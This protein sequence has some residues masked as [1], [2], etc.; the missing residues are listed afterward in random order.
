[1]T[2]LS[3]QRSEAHVFYAKIENKKNV[4]KSENW[5]MAVN[6]NQSQNK[7]NQN[8]RRFN[9]KRGQ[10]RNNNSSVPGNNSQNGNK[11]KSREYKFHMH[12]MLQWKML[13][14]FNNIKESI[15]LKV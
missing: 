6:Q 15:I 7:N 5:K 10:N 3:S 13:E 11:P 8:R 12:D 1:M 9:R 14:S 2:L 4:K